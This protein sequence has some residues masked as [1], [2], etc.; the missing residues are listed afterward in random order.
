VAANLA[1][2][3]QAVAISARDRSTLPRLIEHMQ[4][5]IWEQL[6]DDPRLAAAST[7]SA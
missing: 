5:V 6:H 1:R 4:D 3:H 7:A 2:L